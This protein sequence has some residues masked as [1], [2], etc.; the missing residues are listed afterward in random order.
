[1]PADVTE[2]P[3]GSRAPKDR[4]LRRTVITASTRLLDLPTRYGFH[5]LIAARLPIAEVGAFYI[6]FS[7]MTLA[8]GFGRFGVDR[9]VT[10]EVAAALGR[11]RPQSAR[12]VI[13]HGFRSMLLFSGAI[14]ALLV[15]ASRPLAVYVLHKPAL[16]WPLA[17]GA[18]TIL[19]QNLANAAAGALAGLGR[20]ATSQ[21][22][23]QW[24]WPGLFCVA[25]LSLPLT[26]NVTL[27]LIIA[28]LTLNAVVGI[29]LM[30][31]VLPTLHPEIE[32]MKQPSLLKL[33]I[34]LFSLELL[35]LAI[36]AA[37]PFVLGIV[38]ATTDVGRYALAWRLVLMLNLLVSAM[39]AIAAPQF[40]RASA[41]SDF[42]SLRKVASQSVAFCGGLSILPAILLA[43][44]PAFFLSRF[45]TAYAP[46]APALRVLLVG[47]I[48]LIL[49]TAVPEMLGMTGHAKTLLKINGASLLVLLAGL[50]VLPSRFGALG[51]A[52]ATALTMIVSALAVSYS[53]RR[54][55]GIVPLQLALY[56]LRR[57]LREAL[58]P[59]TASERPSESDIQDID[60]S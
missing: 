46:A 7:V 32:T 35:Q 13:W 47:Q 18:I 59:A 29:G 57:K 20:V 33:G 4:F 58:S 30:F 37:P 26:L 41:K 53:A 14:T 10:R 31:R 60:N 5:F 50:S 11:D 39:G 25:A 2:R 22:I 19:P 27:L 55:L 44:N 43:I 6:V 17:L 34:Q 54:D 12:S 36:S 15:L 45:G 38:A 49:S 42:A 24:L 48:F 9:S 28:C 8:S 52:T 56:D 16:A 51:A 3:G 23:Y 1:M 21:M 40:A